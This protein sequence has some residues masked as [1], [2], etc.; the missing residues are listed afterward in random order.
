M[1]D[2]LHVYRVRVC[3][4]VC[5]W[6]GW[7]IA[8]ILACIFVCVCCCDCS[9]TFPCMRV[10]LTKCCIPIF[11][12]AEFPFYLRRDYYCFSIISHS[13]SFRRIAPSSSPASEHHMLRIRQF[14]MS[15]E[16]LY[17]KQNYILEPF[18]VQHIKQHRFP[19]LLLCT[20]P[21]K[22]ME[23]AAGRYAK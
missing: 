6:W 18:D 22:C 12:I 10:Y 21:S 3:A 5:A 17:W 15:T 20:N 7:L 4:C 19:L 16:S 11:F 8:G 14:N 23:R 2:C 13:W 9:Y 1:R